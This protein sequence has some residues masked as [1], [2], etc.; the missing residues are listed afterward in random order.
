M[1]CYDRPTDVSDMPVGSL[2]LRADNNRAGPRDRVLKNA[3]LVFNGAVVDCSVLDI[4]AQGAR[5][6]LRTPMAMPSVVAFHLRG[7]AIYQA[8]R[9]WARG[10]EVG[11]EFSSDPTLDAVTAEMAWPVYESLRD[12]APDKV[13][14]S[15]QAYRHFDDPALPALAQQLADAYAALATAL[16]QRAARG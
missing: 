14:A 10:L 16:R 9:A 2:V 8:R 15:L 5:I 6:L 4:S 3:K 1:K 7:G 12:L 13:I 11:F